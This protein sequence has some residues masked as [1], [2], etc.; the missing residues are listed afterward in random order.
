[1]ANAYAP[2]P[3]PEELAMNY[4][5][6]RDDE[7]GM[8]DDELEGLV[9]AE[10]SD[11]V[12][13][14]DSE[15]GK[16]RT[17]AI[18]FYRGDPL[19][20][21]EEGRSKFVSRD[22]ADTINAILPSLMRVFFGPEHV[23]EFVPEC[24]EDEAVADQQTDYI[25]YIVT[26]DNPGFEIFYAA[27]KNALRE[28]VGIVKYWWDDAIEVR[29]RHYTGLD[30]DGL[31]KLLEDVDAAEDYEITDKEEGE[32][33]ISITLKLKRKR[34]KAKIEAVP[35]EEFLIN[36]DAKSIE[37]ARIVA[38]RRD[39]TV[40]DL[41]AMGYP[42][43]FVEEN[44]GYEDD[45][46]ANQERQARNPYSQGMKHSPGG[47]KTVTMA[48]Y[49]ESYVNIDY[50]GDGIAELMKVCTIGGKLAA[51]EPVDERPF[52]DFHCD[53]EPHTFFGESLA[54]K[55]TDIQVLKSALIRAGL[56]G[57][58]ASIFPRLVVT[59]GANS[60]DVLNNEVGAV[61]RVKQATDVTAISVPD[62]SGDAL[63][64]LGYADEVRENR[65]GMSK[66]SMGLDAEALQ[67]T[68]AT[69]AEGQFARSQE[70]IE[71]IARIM[72][73][74]FRRL[75]VGLS[76]LVAANQRKERMVK[77]R[78]QWVQ[79]DPRA[80][81][82]DMDVQPNVGLGG[83]TNQQKAQLLSLV[84]TKQ[85]G[86]FQ[87]YGLQN[88]FVSVKHY[89]DTMGR[90]IEL[91][92]FKNPQSFFMAPEQAEAMM[93]AQAA[94]PP[95]P[96]PKVIEVQ[97]RLQLAE[98]KQSHDMEHDV[99]KFEHD[100]AKSVAEH[101]LK[102]EQIDAEL[103]LKRETTAA[104]LDLKREQLAAELQL[105]REQMTAE[106]ALKTAQAEHSAQMA[107]QSSDIGDVA[108]GGEPG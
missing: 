7:G 106:L 5:D 14:I 105:K 58:S 68:T 43:E 44:A 97:G 82:S 22:V 56:D 53:P 12:S 41:V 64:W 29:T 36:R 31:T 67:N 50:D 93:K 78:N 81:R 35:P 18:E 77:L 85:E 84:L 20:N 55:A 91:A 98:A 100:Q 24:E 74:G 6:E 59:D 42:R 69:A 54:D 76:H 101:D 23:V 48:R 8:S 27:I 89:L 87:T 51:K 63:N 11:A 83:G 75:F 70:R 108:V 94:Q 1:M 15:I 99:A 28:K 9:E 52:A 38:H 88:P 47:D 107:E 3:F 17:K 25:N 62:K 16:A 34:D 71:L 66:V 13:F 86:I 40:S 102:R 26:R 33:G 95:P 45:L 96:D 46:N 32:D 80:W 49:V 61:I 92:G 30:M 19:G 103:T 57:L 60:D 73:S 21:E 2:D 37:D 90:F 65:T 72:A 39:M 4:G 104:E 10:V 79:I